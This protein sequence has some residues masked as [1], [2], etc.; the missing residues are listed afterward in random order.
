[1][2]NHTQQERIDDVIIRLRDR[3]FRLTPQRLAV[4]KVMLKSNTHLSAEEIYENI[5]KDYPMI[6]LA[7]IYKTITMLKE[8]G[9]ITELN[10][11][12]QSARFEP[13]DHKPHPHFI[14]SKCGRIIDL[15]H[16]ILDNLPEKIMKTTG[17]QIVR[18]RLDFYGLCQ[19]CQSG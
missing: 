5:H 12:S 4:L 8:M 3:G 10:F 17:H 9:E 1:M 7:T 18:T 16:H 11:N 13:F 2:S 14:C 19:N 15:D 6:G